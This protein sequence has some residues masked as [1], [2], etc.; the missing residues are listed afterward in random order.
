VFPRTS[1]PHDGWVAYGSSST[2]TSDDAFAGGDH[3]V[4]LPAAVRYGTVSIS[5]YGGRADTRYRDS[6]RVEVYDSLQNFSNQSFR[7]SPAVGNHAGP[8]MRADGLLIRG[9]VLRWMTLTSGVAWYD[10]KSYTVRF[11]Y[12]VLG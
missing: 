5:A 2:C 8:R 3:S 6:A 4:R 11:T 10:V 12:F 9:R 7:L 1:G